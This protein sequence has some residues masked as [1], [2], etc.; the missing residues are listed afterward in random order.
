[1]LKEIEKM[2]NPLEYESKAMISRTWL[3]VVLALAFS[4]FLIFGVM[5]FLNGNPAGLLGFVPLALFAAVIFLWE[6]K[7]YVLDDAELKI[8]SNKRTV[9]IPISSMDEVLL[10]TTAGRGGPVS[11]K[12]RV[13]YGE[14]EE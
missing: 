3:F 9:V 13:R 12:L 10:F 5:A 8:I 11:W 7:T 6:D 2:P 14:K 4:P 1:M